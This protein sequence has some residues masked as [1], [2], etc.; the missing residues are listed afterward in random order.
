[1][2]LI[3]P[4]LIALLLL[5]LVAAVG[6]STCFPHL[7]F[8]GYTVVRLVP[9]TDVEFQARA[10][11]QQAKPGTIIE[12]PAGNWTFEDELIVATSHIV[13]RGRGA[14]ATTMAIR[15]IC[16]V[17]GSGPSSPP[18]SSRRRRSSS[19]RLPGRG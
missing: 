19:S 16:S 13:L 11:L 5:P 4:A 6:P 10:A 14:L 7:E 17:V 15:A 1:M 12:F 18:D 9:G 3:K 2:R 8:P